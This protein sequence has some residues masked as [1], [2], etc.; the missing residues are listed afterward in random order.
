MCHDLADI[1]ATT[2]PQPIDIVRGPLLKDCRV[3]SGRVEVLL[4]PSLQEN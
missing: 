1:F 2:R 4:K 3:T